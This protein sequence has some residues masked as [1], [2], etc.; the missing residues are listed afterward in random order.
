[1]APRRINIH[2]VV[3][4][5]VYTCLAELSHSHH[6]PK[7]SSHDAGNM[8]LT[9]D[10]S[11]T[12]TEMHTGGEPLRIIES[13]WPD[14]EGTTILEKRRFARERHDALRRFLMFEPRGHSDMY[15]ALL[16]KPD[17]ED[18][19]LAVLFMHNEGYS[20]MCGHAVIALGRYA[21]DRGLVAPSNGAETEVKIQCPC[22]LVRTF[23]E[24]RDGKPGISVRF[25]SV[26][27]FAYKLGGYHPCKHNMACHCRAIIGPASARLWPS[28]G[29]VSYIPLVP[30]IYASVNRVSIGSDLSRRLFGAKPL[31]EPI[32]AG[33]LP[34]GPL[35]TNFSEILIK[36]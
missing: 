31:S 34:I 36:M 13:G 11:I 18:A 4:A 16:V 29:T 23:V 26:P 3:R 14:L 1:M 2:Q 27:A 19:D 24:T 30:H 15:G 12:T 7:K 33:L 8:S 22:G 35:G 5:E 20:T 10:L 6:R 21:L 9:R 28:S 17:I 32:N 25:H